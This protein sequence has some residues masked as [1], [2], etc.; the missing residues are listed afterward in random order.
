VVCGGIPGG[1]QVPGGPGPVE[2]AGVDPYGSDPYGYDPYGEWGV[3][4][5]DS[6]GY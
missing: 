6:G 2:S 5:G 1:P 3:E 4:E